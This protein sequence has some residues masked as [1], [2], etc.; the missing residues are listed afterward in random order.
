MRQTILRSA[1]VLLFISISAQMA[2]AN[3]GAWLSPVLYVPGLVVLSPLLG[4]PVTLAAAILER[5][6]VSLAGVRTH[7]LTR[8]IRAN[9]LS[10]LVGLV[11]MVVVIFFALPVTY[12]DRVLSGDP[13]VSVFALWLL[14]MAYYIL[15]IP[16]SIL[17]EGGYYRAILRRQR[18]VLRWRWVVAANVFSN[19]VLVAMAFVPAILR[20]N[21]P[22]LVRNVEPHLETLWWLL[23]AI[24]AALVLFALRPLGKGQPAVP[25][26]TEHGPGSECDAAERSLTHAGVRARGNS[27]VPE[28][29]SF[30]EESHQ[31]VD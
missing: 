5:P 18:G 28:S 9:L 17:I 13:I 14:E 20:K 31:H 23:A 3:G 2:W 21:D 8:S 26:A 12:L 11:F 4:L 29:E 27:N 6:F 15:A 7:A 1:L 19:V 10:W 25:E 16:I 24:S 22:T 30:C